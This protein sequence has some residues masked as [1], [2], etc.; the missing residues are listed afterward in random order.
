[1]SKSYLIPNSAEPGYSAIMR[2]RDYKD[3][4]L[5][6]TYDGVSTLYESFQRAVKISD[7]K[8]LI[9]SR[10]F[11]PITQ[12]F[13]KYEWT[14]ANEAAE[15]V[16]NFG[17]GLDHIYEK[18]APEVDERGQQAL[19]IYSINR[20]EWLLSE[21]GGF[22]SR[23]YSVA[24]YD[25]L[26]AQSVEYIMNHADVRVIA[27]SIDKI[28]KLLKL[29]D[30][31]PNLKAI[32][33]MDSFDDH[34]KNPVA[35]PFTV[36]SIRVL[37]E[38]A[39]SKGVKLFDMHQV[40]EMGRANPT[41]PKLP[42]P[43][44]I[45]TICYT[46]GTTGNP[47]GAISTHANY[48]F[49]SKSSHHSIPI[50][51]CVYLS[52]LPLAHCFERNLTYVGLLAGGRIGF[53]SGDVLRIAEDA[54]ILKPTIMIGVPRLFNRIYD[55]ITASTIYAPGLTGIIARTAIK[56]KLANLE[57]GNGVKHALWD[58][59]ICNKIAQ[60]FG[61][62]LQI[63]ISGSAPIDAKVLNFLRVAIACTV[64][65]GYGQT[66][67]NAN[68]TV[69]LID[70][71]TAGH[72]GVPHPGVD[73]R[74]RDAPEMNYLASDEPCPRGE[75]MIRSKCN[76]VGYHKDPE[77]TKETF[78]NE[79][80]LTG[81]IARFNE[82]GNISIIDRRK[83]IFKLAQGEYVA[84]EHLETVYNKHPLIQNIYIH[85]DSLQSEL[86]GVVVPDPDVFVPWGQKITGNKG[87]TLESL[88]NDKQVV[89]ALL[90]E[91]RQ[92]GRQARLQGFEIVKDIYCDH[93]PFDI[94]TNGLLTS[95]FKLK[96]NEAAAYYR[97]QIDEMYV[98]INGARK[99]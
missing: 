74:L 58:R 5:V 64:L 95:T 86:V 25:T 31:I 78:E 34:A 53:Y 11:N 44:D 85:G 41:T 55:R 20:P 38:W 24:L 69:C 13:G 6:N 98:R 60:F 7:N 71:N 77:K 27:C 4:E 33:S 18:Y 32:L 57:A 39:E 92:H 67:C 19:G 82:D 16:D 26:G 23:R 8:P 47:K 48:V 96:R 65:E 90:V 88:A 30:S 28:P 50:K 73:V 68:A 12:K 1:M 46:S 81:D 70:E 17:S 66:E 37:H 43:E 83:N 91:L 10:A 56:Q 3:G 93:V 80:L 87:D 40:I 97:P 59:I 29:K 72:V 35:R 94:E 21:F 2:H 99:K 51:N 54:Q 14:T 49:S 63:L 36:N 22:R 52:F 45:C 9:G 15:I 79:W 42:S 62:N 89:G 75:L 76:F 61:G 84:P